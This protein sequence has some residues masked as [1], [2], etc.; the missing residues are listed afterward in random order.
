MIY[1][2][3]EYTAERFTAYFNLDTQMI[4][5]FSLNDAQKD[6]LVGLALYKIQKFLRE[7]LRLRSACDLRMTGSK[8]TMPESGVELPSFEELEEWVSSQTKELFK[9]IKDP[10]GL[11][12]STT[13]LELLEG[14]KSSKKAEE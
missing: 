10:F 6:Y 2:R 1:S 11:G 12:L 7:G 4:N 5:G 9:D 3:V 13:P 14:K 8:V